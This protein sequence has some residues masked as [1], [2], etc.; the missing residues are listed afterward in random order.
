ML[1]YLYIRT[2]R[3]YWNRGV[4]VMGMRINQ[5]QNFGRSLC[6][7]PPE[8]MS[9][10][11]RRHRQKVLTRH[12]GS[13]EFAPRFHIAHGQALQSKGQAQNI[14]LLTTARAGRSLRGT[15]PQISITRRI[16]DPTARF[17]HAQNPWANPSMSGGLGNITP[18]RREY[19]A[20]LLVAVLSLLTS[21]KGKWSQ[22]QHKEATHA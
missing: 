4:S 19:P 5:Q 6:T 8:V 10:P 20:L 3:I 15:E 12:G 9:T 2:Y 11:T 16:S 21:L 14:S 18:L 13:R 22:N 7:L 1:P 17:F